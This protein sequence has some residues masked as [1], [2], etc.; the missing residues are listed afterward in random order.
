MLV[1]LAAV[2]VLRGAK[3]LRT[4]LVVAVVG[5]LAN[6]AL[7]Y[8][9]VYPLG[10]G[11][12]GSALGSLLAQTG[13]AAALLI[14]VVRTAVRE[15]APLVPD[16][17]GI[18]R[19]AVVGV[20][21]IV[22]TLMLR[23]ALLVMTAG[24]AAFG[25]TDLATMQLALSIWTFLAFA[26]D[27]LGISAQTLV[28]NQLGTG[29]AVRARAVTQRLIGWGVVLGV[30]TG[31]LLLACSAGLGRLFTEDPAVLALLSP[32]LLVAAV[33]Q[34]FAGVVFTLDGILIGAGDGRYLAWA[35]TVVLAVFAPL[36]WYAVAGPG[37][38]LALWVAF[39]VGFMGTRTVVLVLRSRSDAWMRLGA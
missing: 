2:G 30:A 39:A 35:Q 36:A 28:G 15:G 16:L 19:A 4:P 7:N 5:N 32:V 20:P 1:M 24:A 22:R 25:A 31:L 8:A 17:P 11:I 18:R 37:T 10:L 38:L 27:A 14:V 12:R 3:D 9:L 21:L 34:P 26:L 33:A 29:D 13:S 23:A 6:I